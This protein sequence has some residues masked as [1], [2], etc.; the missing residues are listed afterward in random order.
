MNLYRD[1]ELLLDELVTRTYSLAQVNEV[2][3]D[4]RQHPDHP[5]TDPLRVAADAGRPSGRGDR[6][7]EEPSIATIS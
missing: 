5:R 2:Y 6:C 1:G 4:M 3:D 7:P